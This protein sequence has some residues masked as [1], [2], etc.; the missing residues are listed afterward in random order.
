MSELPYMPEH[1]HDLM[2]ETASLSNEELGAFMRLR[3]A[4]WRAGG[5]LPK[6][7]IERAV[8]A[9]SAWERLAPTIMARLT[10]AGRIVSNSSLL[11]LLIR[12]RERREKARSQAGKA[13]AARWQKAGKLENISPINSLADAQALPE[14]ANQNQNHID[15]KILSIDAYAYGEPLL[16]DSVGM[17]NLAARSQLARWIARVGDEELVSILAAV[18]REG[19][20]GPGLVNV[21]DQKVVMIE[22]LKKH[23]PTLPFPPNA[24]KSLK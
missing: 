7:E 18:K 12:T 9:G 22:R 1:V 4:L 21:V 24:V 3:W 8:Q 2:A 13:A 15:S 10:L 23:G 16:V 19:L 14:H 17:R 6:R 20:R 5:Y 11:E